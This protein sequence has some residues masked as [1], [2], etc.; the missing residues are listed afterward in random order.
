MLQSTE[1]PLVGLPTTQTGLSW[2]EGAWVEIWQ[3]EKNRCSG[4]VG[5]EGL[6]LAYVYI[7]MST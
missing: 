7:Y 1:G 5:L 4:F 6:K 3:F 2:E